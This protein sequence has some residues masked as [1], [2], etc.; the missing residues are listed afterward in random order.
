MSL[1]VDEM[2]D[3]LYVEPAAQGHGDRHR[4][5]RP[6]EG[7][8]AAT[9]FTFWVVPAEREGAPLLRT[10]RLQARPARRRVGERGEDAGRPVRMETGGGRVTRAL[11]VVD[12]QNDYFPGG[13]YPLD[14]PEEAAAQ[15]RLLLDAFRGSGETIVHMQHVWDAPGRGVHAARHGG[16]RDP[17]ARRARGRR[18]GAAEGAPEQLPRHGPR[19]LPAQS[20]AARRH[21][22][23]LRDDD[24]HVRGRHRPRGRGSRLRD[25]RRTRRVRRPGSRIRRP[26][27]RRLPTCTPHS[28]PPSPGGY[29]RALGGGLAAAAEVPSR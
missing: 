12:I 28:S 14:G 21:A 17:R 2:L 20:Q 11:I 26:R 16:R 27:G 23:R 6:G 4:A 18:D 24:E 8:P 9:G 22:R 5:A 3:H 1:A 13:A 7:A 10:A 25:E 15:A 19:E 29:A